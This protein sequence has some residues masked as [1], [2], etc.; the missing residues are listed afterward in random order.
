MKDRNGDVLDLGDVVVVESG[1]HAGLV[2][3]VEA[4]AGT[5]AL[6]VAPEL[7]A[8][9]STMQTVSRRDVRLAN[10]I[11]RARWKRDAKARE[12]AASDAWM[13]R[14]PPEHLRGD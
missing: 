8:P 9:L 13:G 6:E 7:W 4:W 5:R 12:K 10:D 11:E 14:P 2:G 1:P 3:R